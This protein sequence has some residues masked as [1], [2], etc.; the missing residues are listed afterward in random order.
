MSFEY[1]ARAV[2]QMLDFLVENSWEINQVDREASLEALKDLIPEP[3]FNTL[4]EK[5]AEP[6]EMSTESGSTL[7]FRYN[8]YI[9]AI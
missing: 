7:R 6:N 9:Y 5:Y 8:E 2:T 3:V 4:F 1:E